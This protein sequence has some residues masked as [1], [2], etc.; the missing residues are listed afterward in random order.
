MFGAPM[1]LLIVEDN[2]E[3]GQ[4]L[5]SGLKQSGY[6]TDLIHTA[7]EA[8]L[9]LSSMQ[10]AAVVLD[11]GLPDAD[12]LSLLK[13]VR[14]QKNPIPILVLTARSGVQDRVS[15]LRAGADDYLVKPFV[16]DELIARLEALLRR[17]GQFMG[18]PI[19]AA[20]IIFDTANRQ[21]FIDDIP[22]LLSA[23]ETAVLE[24]LMRSKGRVLSKK[25]VEDQI[26]GFS[27]D[28]ASNAVEVYIHRLRKQLSEH[29]A[30]IQIHTVRGIGYLLA[31]EF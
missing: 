4:L 1:R 28:V 24:L 12:G 22:Q 10:Y 19:R 11:L 30:R 26:F 8:R 18:N 23:R 29:G 13:N 27:G 7:A 31:E 21:V 5:V 20:N 9:A 3:L 15:G 17:P 2:A 25:Q 6:E 16:F 14:Q